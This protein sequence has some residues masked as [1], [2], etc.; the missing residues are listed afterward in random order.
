MRILYLAHRIPFPAN[1]GERIRALRLIR[2]LAQRHE[3][4]CACFRDDPTEHRAEELETIV[5]RLGVVDLPRRGALL[6][7]AKSV[8]AGA[9]LTEGFFS[10]PAMTALVNTWMNETRFDA[11]VAFSSSTAGLALSVPAPR[12]I[13]DLCDLDSAKWREYAERSTWPVSAVYATEARRLA[14]KELSWID[15]FDVSIVACRRELEAISDAPLRRKTRI[16]RNGVDL[17]PD[18]GDASGASGPPI[19]IFVGDL[20][21]RPN[22][23]GLAWF[24]EH[25]WPGIVTRSP[26]AELHLVGRRPARR[27]ARLAG[28]HGVRVFADVPDV[29]PFLR[30][31]HVSVAPIHVARGVQN[32]VLEALAW[33]KPVVMTSA[34]ARG[35]DAGLSEPWITA[36]DAGA[37]ID[38]TARLLADADLR[39]AIGGAARSFA[40][41][42]YAWGPQL[43]A[44]ERLVTGEMTVTRPAQPRTSARSELSGTFASGE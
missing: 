17:P 34:V 30:A 13:L 5:H 38:G 27:I 37:F 21:Y 3:L 19:V 16:V 7:A 6:R 24:V 39:R 8:L 42:E 32:K 18:T 28:T 36:D 41:L 43:A 40:R 20:S 1:K 29:A 4:W 26:H 33:A 12:R 11:V 14:G 22:V 23:K 10:H 2:H 31:A 25:C 35:L 9:T 44:F 15:A